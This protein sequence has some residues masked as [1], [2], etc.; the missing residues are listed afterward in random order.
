MVKQSSARSDTVKESGKKNS[1]VI[2]GSINWSNSLQLDTIVI[3]RSSE[4]SSD[5]LDSG[6]GEQ[7]SV[8]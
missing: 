7:S 8:S 6:Y 5:R 3:E 4:R 1:V 2:Q